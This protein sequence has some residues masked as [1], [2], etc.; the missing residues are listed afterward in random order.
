MFGCASLHVF[1]SAAGWILSED[2]Y[3]RLLST[4][5][6]RVTLIVSGTDACPWDVSQVG[7]VIG[8]QF[9]H[10]P[11]CVTAFLVDRMNF[12]LKVL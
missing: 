8:W 7:M 6:T 11:L 1:Q 12:E 9:P 2:S 4:C 3:A 5:I 10:S